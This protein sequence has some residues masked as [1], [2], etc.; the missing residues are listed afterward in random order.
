MSSTFGKVMF[1][2][3]FLTASCTGGQI[4]GGGVEESVS[5]P[6][7]ALH[8]PSL[9]EEPGPRPPAP[10]V[11]SSAPELPLIEVTDQGQSVS[12][13]FLITN[14]SASALE[15]VAVGLDVLDQGGFLLDRKL[16]DFHGV[17][18]AILTLPTREIGPGETLYLFNPFQVLSERLPLDTLRFSFSFVAEDTGE[19]TTSL[20]EVNPAPY[21]ART[22][23]GL[24]LQ[25]RVLVAAGHDFYAPHRRIDLTDPFVQA[26]G[27]QANNARYANDF[28]LI[29][30]VGQLF[31]GDGTAL[32]D[33]FGFLAPVY[34]P[35]DGTVIF[36]NDGIPDNSFAGPGQ[37]V[38]SDALAQGGAGAIFGNFVLIDHGNGEVSLLAHLEQGSFLVGP[39]AHVN[40][41]QPLAKVGFS[42][43]TDF[44]HTHYQLQD[45]P[46]LATAEGLPSYFTKFKRLI[47][48]HPLTVELGAVDT[49]DVVRP[50]F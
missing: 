40:R 28:T 43:N 35:G 16:I 26:V 49:G 18:P 42:G 22:S 39:G 19:V 27:L 46:D 38:F 14:D 23:L 41:G 13:D 44:I 1:Y 24:P 31:C 48:A 8:Q 5:P 37:V 33:W 25:G 30:E 20:I 9:C 36:V 17:S 10:V 50:I 11:I 47:G 4:D 29:N 2:G 7:L 6:D 3:I 32:S 45:S 12:V 15:I 34:A 21:R